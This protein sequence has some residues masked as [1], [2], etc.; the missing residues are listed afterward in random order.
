MTIK[1]ERD[2][3][4][5]V[6]WRIGARGRKLFRHTYRNTE[7]QQVACSK[8]QT[9]TSTRNHQREMLVTKPEPVTKATMRETYE[10]LVADAEYAESTLDVHRAAWKYIA[11]LADMPAGKITPKQSS[12]ALKAVPGAEMRAKVRQLL[13]NL[14]APVPTDRKPNTRAK[15][16]Q[17][18]RK[19]LRTISAEELAGLV[20]EMP[21]R[22]RALVEVMA[23]QGLRPGE[24]VSLRVGDFDPLRRTLKI[25]RSLSGFTKTGIA[26]S[27]TLPSSVAA[28]LVAHIASFSDATDQNAP[29]FTTASGTPIASKF[30]YD[31]WVRRH[32]KPAVGRAH[33]EHHLS[34]NDLRHYAVKFA[35]GHGADVFAVQKML[36]HAKPSITLDVYGAEWESHAEELAERM[37]APIRAA[38][39]ER[40]K[41]AEVVSLS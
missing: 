7:R 32:F 11:H 30:A 24:A 10:Q 16:M 35:I 13:T 14:G 41:P 23:Y 21:D 22:Y 4:P 39:A 5:G 8:H 26:R 9:I 18:T 20:T 15:R 1:W 29:M 38:R 31:S 3:V 28:L 27:L 6:Y 34:P 36:G 25:E 19:P 40:P 33:I 17:Q 12:D 2:T 37:D